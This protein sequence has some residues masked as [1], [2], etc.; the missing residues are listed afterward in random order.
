M[1]G[2]IP[3]VLGKQTGFIGIISRKNSKN[4]KACQ[5]KKVIPR[6]GRSGFQDCFM[7]LL[8]WCGKS[9]QLLSISKTG[10]AQMD[11]QTPFQK[12][13]SSPEVNGHWSCMVRMVPIIKI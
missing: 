4:K 12:W 2:T 6:T 3:H 13:I 7:H 10:G 9:G 8:I 1:G 11:L 5:P